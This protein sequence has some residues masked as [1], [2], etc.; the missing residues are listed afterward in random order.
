MLT[1]PNIVVLEDVFMDDE[2]LILIFEM[3]SMDLRMY[4]NSLPMET[5]MNPELVR[6]YL[7]QVTSAILFCHLNRVLHRDLKPDNLLINRQGL[8]KVGDFGLARSFSIPVRKLSLEIVTLW[9]RAPEIL[10]TSEAYST[11]IDIWSLGCIFAEMATRD[12]LFQGDSEID[13]L[14]RIFRV[15]GTPTA[16]TWPGV[17][18]LPD[19]HS[20]FP[21]WI[22]NKLEALIEDNVDLNG[23]DLLQKMLILDPTKRISAKEMIEHKY[24]ENVKEVLPIL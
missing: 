6:S 11:S 15:L 3:L 7:Y 22:E 13:Q 9:Y 12:A 21:N 18:K 1:H 20:Q 4:L 8:I 2:E 17:D 5:M 24:F 23:F 10:M 16:E 19:F 14:F